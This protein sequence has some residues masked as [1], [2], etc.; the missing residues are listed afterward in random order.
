MADTDVRTHA[1]LRGQCAHVEQ[2]GNKSIVEVP[3]A[4]RIAISINYTEIW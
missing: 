4:E 1:R 3:G 2:W